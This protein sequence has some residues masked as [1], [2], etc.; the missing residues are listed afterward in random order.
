MAQDSPQHEIG[1]GRVRIEP[2]TQD[3][4]RWREEVDRWI[5]G[6]AEQMDRIFDGPGTDV[7]G[8]GGTLGGLPTPDRLTPTDVDRMLGAEETDRRLDDVVDLLREIRGLLEQRGT[9]G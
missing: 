9:D 4:D 1:R 3:F 7:P 6:L 8:T 2:D 5:E